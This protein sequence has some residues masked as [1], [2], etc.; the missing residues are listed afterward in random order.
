MSFIL[1]HIWVIFILGTC[2]NAYYGW[3]AVQ[4]RIRKQPELEM[5][6]RSLFKGYAI[7]LN[8]PLVLMGVGI[9]SGQV[10]SVFD[11]IKPGNGNSYVLFWYFSI[12]VLLIY[13]LNWIF[14]EK[15][16]ETLAKHP[17]IPMIPQWSAKKLRYYSM[18][19]FIWNIAGGCLLFIASRSISLNYS[20]FSEQGF[21]DWFGNLFPIFFI[22]MWVSISFLLAA[23]GGWNVLAKHYSART[24]FLGELFWF[25]SGKLGGLVN[26]GSCLTLGS[27]SQGLHLSV[28]FPFRIGHPPLFIPW[29]DI[30]ACSKK[31]WFF[32]TVD[33]EFSKSPGNT[34]RIF[35][36]TAEKLAIESKGRF[37]F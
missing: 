1:K 14:L 29:S 33:L 9:I 8:V 27:N 26:Y 37:H 5:G 17:G 16:A 23:M 6:Y 13:F 28:L 31:G 21:P 18:G 34:L 30:V 36:G 25:C 32:H 7:W 2:Y 22:A 12:L 20:E 35:R 15:G 10:N 24:S 19:I 3:S 4:H 11:F